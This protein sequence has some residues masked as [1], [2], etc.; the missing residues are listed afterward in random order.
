MEKELC[1]WLAYLWYQYIHF[2]KILLECDWHI[3]IHLHFNF[4]LTYPEKQTKRATTEY[5]EI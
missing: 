2:F 4:T 5:E 3:N 1:T